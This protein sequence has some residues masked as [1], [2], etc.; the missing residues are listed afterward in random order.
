[1]ID[2]LDD[3]SVSAGILSRVLTAV[4]AVS[5]AARWFAGGR[6][7]AVPLTVPVPVKAQ[8]AAPAWGPTPKQSAAAQQLFGSQDA[9]PIPAYV[10]Q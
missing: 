8:Q 7:G 10:L 3:F 6:Q 1:M 4:D 2:K 5:T 9:K